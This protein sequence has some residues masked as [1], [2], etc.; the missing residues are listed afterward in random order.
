M[1][2]KM[3]RLGKDYKGILGA[4]IGDISGSSY[5]FNP[6]IKPTNES[7]A[8]LFPEGSKFTD[9]TVMTAAVADNLKNG[10]KFKISQSLRY[11]G[12]LYPN[13]GYGLRFSDWLICSGAKAY[14]SYGN[15]SAMRVSSVAYFAKNENDAIALS[16]MVTECTHNHPE[17]IKGAETVTVLIYR[18]L[19]GENKDELEKYALSKYDFDK[20]DFK[21][22][23]A[24]MGH[25]DE[26]CQ[27]TVPQA[28]WAFF[29]TDSFEDCLRTCLAIGWDAD[30]LAAIACS[31]AEAYY[32][33]IPAY[34]VDEAKKRLDKRVTTALESVPT[35]RTLIQVANEPKPKQAFDLTGIE[36]LLNPSIERG[37]EFYYIAIIQ[38]YAE[39]NKEVLTDFSVHIIDL[40]NGKK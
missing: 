15:G 14:F 21:D 32:K 1:E 10:G 25:G 5:E 39:D 19:H 20:L 17:G 40:I 3:M 26:T 12:S 35:D 7:D 23:K 38:K 30:T 16:K 4:A 37:Y 22:M 18:S 27:V 9:D 6:S 31:I 34:I 36:N 33:R 28:L 11:W 13:A 29:H 8:V 2:K 24:F